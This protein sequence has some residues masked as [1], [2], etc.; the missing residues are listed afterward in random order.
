MCD[1]QYHVV[2]D[3]CCE[4]KKVNKEECSYQR[5]LLTDLLLKR[6]SPNCPILRK[7]Y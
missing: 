5:L 4:N 3:V 2:C 7:I 6:Q 1:C